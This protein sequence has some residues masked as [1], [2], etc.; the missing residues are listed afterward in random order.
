MECCVTEK[1]SRGTN[2]IDVKYDILHD[3]LTNAINKHIPVKTAKFD[4][5]KHRKSHWITNGIIKSIRFRD[6]L[7]LKLKKTPID[8]IEFR[9]SQQNLKTYN[10]ILRKKC[11]IGKAILL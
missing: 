8:S 6:N 3:T 5:H 1:I 10:A 9:C 4:K 7:Y 11:K 2:D